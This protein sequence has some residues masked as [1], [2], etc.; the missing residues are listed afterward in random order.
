MKSKTDLFEVDGK[1]CSYG[2][3]TTVLIGHTDRVVFIGVP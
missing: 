3:Q 2:I 1:N